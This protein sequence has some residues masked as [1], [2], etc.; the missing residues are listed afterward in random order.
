MYLHIINIYYVILHYR[1]SLKIKGPKRHRI[2]KMVEWMYLSTSGPCA[3]FPQD[4]EGYSV[5]DIT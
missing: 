5:Y 4:R 1:N 3:G 2:Y